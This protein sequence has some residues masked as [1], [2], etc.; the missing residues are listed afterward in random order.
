MRIFISLTF[1]PSTV[2]EVI[3]LHMTLNEITPPLSSC[4]VLLAVQLKH[5]IPSLNMDP[6]AELVS[7]FVTASKGIWYT[8]S[9]V[10]EHVSEAEAGRVLSAHKLTATTH[11]RRLRRRRLA[12]RPHGVL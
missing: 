1:K 8:R 7:F 4:C 10:L 6:D 2:I 12:G 9:D 3:W 5:T 11:Q